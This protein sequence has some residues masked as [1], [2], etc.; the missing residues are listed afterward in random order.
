MIIQVRKQ[1]LESGVL[2]NSPEI[3]ETRPRQ[4]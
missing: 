4:V 2:T 1:C 3:G